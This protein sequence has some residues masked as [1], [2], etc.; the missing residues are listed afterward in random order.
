LT[1]ADAAG[2]NAVDML[3]TEKFDTKCLLRIGPPTEGTRLGRTIRWAQQGF[4]WEANPKHRD[5]LLELVG[6]DPDDAQAGRQ[7]WRA[8]QARGF[9]IQ[10]YDRKGRD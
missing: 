6:T 1:R 7:R 9:Q 2:L 4:E 5:G 8:Y 10:P 3:L